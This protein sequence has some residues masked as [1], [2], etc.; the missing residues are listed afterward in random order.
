MNYKVISIDIAKNIFQICGLNQ[1]GKVAFNKKVTRAKLLDTLRQYKTDF[2]VLEA[3][4]A[5]N[6]WG[7][8]IADLGFTVKLIPPYQVKPFLVGNKNDHNDAIAIAEAALRPTA[9][10]VPIKTLEQQDIQSLDRIRERLIKHR[11]AVI[12]QLRGLLSEYGIF[13]KTGT[14]HLIKEIPV[15]LD[16][17]SDSL[18]VIAKKFIRKLADEIN[19][20]NQD[21]IEIENLSEAL[22][23]T[24]P[25]YTH[26]QTVRGIGPVTAAAIIASANTGKQFKNGRCF[27]AW[28]GLTPKQYAS[29]DHSLMKGITKRGNNYLRKCFI[30]GARAVM[31]WCKNKTD[32]FSLWINNLLNRMHPCKAIVAVAHK[33]A[34]IAWAVLVHQQPYHPDK[35]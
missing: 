35:V 19:G 18:T 30:H 28:L 25:S 10:F 9:C 3:C 32:K 20:I 31:N 6:P 24:H 17:P 23:K 29:G 5:S 26:L 34:R 13:V 11:T 16:N 1:Y 22:L 8:A 33:I 21:I 4:Y 14:A 2:I 27:A 12:N 15:I 7:R